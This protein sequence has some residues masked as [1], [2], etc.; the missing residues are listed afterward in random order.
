[1]S[2]GHGVVTQ[3]KVCVVVGKKVDKSRRERILL[4][5]GKL[6][7]ASISIRRTRSDAGGIGMELE[8]KGTVTSGQVYPG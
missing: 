2:V 8:V 1:M 5:G 6:V 7:L 4:P 3:S